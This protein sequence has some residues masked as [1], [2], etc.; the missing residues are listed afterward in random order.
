MPKWNNT[1]SHCRNYFNSKIQKIKSPKTF[2]KSFHLKIKNMSNLPQ[3]NEPVSSDNCPKITISDQMITRWAL[4]IATGSEDMRTDFMKV[5]GLEQLHLPDQIEKQT[6]MENMKASLLTRLS[7]IQD[8][9]GEQDII[10]IRKVILANN[11]DL[12]ISADIDYDIKRTMENL[13]KLKAN[14]ELEILEQK[15]LTFW[16]QTLILKEAKSSFRK[17]M[18]LNG[19]S[20]YPTESSMLTSLSLPKNLDAASISTIE[21]IAGKPNRPNDR[22]PE[23]ISPNQSF[24]INRENARIPLYRSNGGYDK[25]D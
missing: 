16:A 10:D 18:G 7:I 9:L 6:T 20:Y 5:L 12:P 22:Y 21:L 24:S 25:S 11:Y 4:F 8:R 17:A 19:Q 1:C 23:F 15:M 14:T 13:E 2:I 3:C